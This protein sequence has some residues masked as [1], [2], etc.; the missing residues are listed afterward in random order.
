MP[1]KLNAL[2]SIETLGKISR[3][4][5]RI[6]ASAVFL[7]GG[8]LLVWSLMY[9]P[10]QEKIARLR[11]DLEETQGYIRQ[12]QAMVPSGAEER[13]GEGIRLLEQQHNQL[14]ARFPEKEEASLTAL[15]DLARR[16]NVEISTIQSQQ[17]NPCAKESGI[18]GK[19]C[20]ELPVSLSLK[21]DYKDLVEYLELVRTSLPAFVTFE[22]LT[23]QKSGQG[24]LELTAAL[25]IKLYLLV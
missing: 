22:R 9:I 5:K 20:Y 23:L 1:L 21:G 24:A 12:V 8:F 11:R 14:V 15:F 13:I 10:L 2:F 19:K 3:P 7:V 4:Q 6:I 18:E 17:K 25:E 16:A